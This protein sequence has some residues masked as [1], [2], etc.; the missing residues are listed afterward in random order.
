ME[1]S[2]QVLLF[3][4]GSDAKFGKMN[5]SDGR[6]NKTTPI[7]L[8]EILLDSVVPFLGS[9]S[10]RIVKLARQTI[11][12]TLYIPVSGSLA[13][14][15]KTSDLPDAKS[16]PRTNSWLHK[17]HISKL[18]VEKVTEILE[19]LM[20]IPRY[21]IS[22]LRID[23]LL[24]KFASLR[25]CL[26]VS[27]FLFA[28]IMELDV[29][30]K[31]MIGAKFNVKIQTIYN[32]FWF[33]LDYCQ[34]ES[35]LDLKSL[36]IIRAELLD[37][38]CNNKSLET[39]NID[40]GLR[41]CSELLIKSKKALTNLP[42]SQISLCNLL[43][44]L[45]SISLN[46][47]SIF[48]FQQCI[49][50]SSLQ[51]FLYTE[52]M[53]LFHPYLAK[54]L[55]T[56]LFVEIVMLQIDDNIG[57]STVNELEEISNNPFGE[58]NLELKRKQLLESLTL[59]AMGD[60][61]VATQDVRTQVKQQKIE[62]AFEMMGRFN[63]F[64][65]VYDFIMNCTTD[66]F[67]SLSPVLIMSILN[68]LGIIVCV[69]ADCFDL[70][71]GMC[72]KCDNIVGN[73]G[74]PEKD[75]T[76]NETVKR[77]IAALERLLSLNNGFEDQILYQTT[78]LISLKRVFTHCEAPDYEDSNLIFSWLF[79][80]LQSTTR[81]VRILASQTIPLL[82]NE[83]DEPDR[84][85]VPGKEYY[86]DII[87]RELLQI[88]INGKPY[89]SESTI[90]TW[91]RLAC[92]L[93]GERLNVILI[94][95]IDFLGF[96]HEFQVSLAFHQ[97]EMTAKIRH[98]TT[99]QLLS[100]FMPNISL[101]VVKQLARKSS[102][103]QRVSDFINVPLS[104]F[105]VRTQSFTTPYIVLSGRYQ[106]LKSIAQAANKSILNLCM[107]NMEAILGVLLTSAD[108]DNPEA[109][110]EKSASHKLQQI[111]SKFR[112]PIIVKTLILSSPISYAWEI[113]KNVGTD[114]N[115]PEKSKRVRQ[116]LLLLASKFESNSP[117]NSQDS[118]QSF[119]K[120][121]LLGIVQLF[122]DVI[123][124]TKGRKPFTEKLRAV[125]AIGFLAEAA[126][127][128]IVAA[129]PQLC[130]CF[131]AALDIPELERVTFK[132]FG[133]LIE[134]LEDEHL[135]SIIDLV[136]SIVL[137]RWVKM[138]LSTK[139]EAKNI[140]T[141]IISKGP[142][143]KQRYL[144]GLP[145]FNGVSELEEIQEKIQR[146]I[147]STNA[148]EFSIDMKLRNYIRRCSNDNPY[149]VKQTLEEI[150]KYLISN[151]D[152]FLTLK[153]DKYNTSISKLVMSLLEVI[154]KF[155]DNI[156][157][158]PALSSNCLGLIG[159]I[160]VNR[161]DSTKESGDLIILSNF[162]QANESID[163]VI[164]FVQDHL[165]SP[166]WASAD[167]G[168]QLFLAYAMQ[169]YL[170][171]CSLTESVLNGNLPR[172]SPEVIM[173]HSFNEMSRSTLTPLLSSRYSAT[174]LAPEQVTYPIYDLTKTTYSQWL[175]KFTLD[176]LGRARGH[177]SEQIFRVCRRIIKDQDLSISS[178]VLPY[179]A[180]NVI[181]D[182]SDSERKNITNEI[183]YVLK[184]DISSLDND[185]AE[186]LR[187]CYQTIF[188]LVDYFSKWLHSH[189]QASSSKNRGHTLDLPSPAAIE[190]I[191]EVIPSELMAKRSAECG[192]YPRAIL[193]LE[194]CWRE[195][196]DDPIK[197]DKLTKIDFNDTIQSMYAN[198]DDPDSLDGIFV[199]F[200]NNSI[201]DKIKQLRYSDN[202]W[203][204][205]QE[206]YETLDDVKG[207]DKYTID[208]LECLNEHSMHEELLKQINEFIVRK[209]ISESDIPQEWFGLALEA[210]WS[211]GRLNEMKKW[212]KL[213]DTSPNR[214][215]IQSSF[216]FN[217]SKTLV[218]LSE[219]NLEGVDE[220]LKCCREKIWISLTS[221]T[222]N[223]LSQCRSALVKL[224]GLSDLE[225]IAKSSLSDEDFIPDSITRILDN[226]ISSV[227]DDFQSLWYLLSIRRSADILTRYVI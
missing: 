71:I 94:K 111:S 180:L 199:N 15:S 42:R 211:T 39:M 19:K 207:G 171:F 50:P 91:G 79:N 12:L 168:K 82:I 150:K 53:K 167:P 225:S 196:H 14:D 35:A 136:F 102:I 57:T 16:D 169:E 56:I 1:R 72:R 118:L 209:D 11:Q 170:R 88:D 197:K 89:L 55:K 2:P 113:L 98:K 193:Y 130:T 7:Y 190:N 33:I 59:L 192:D 122:S 184:T 181:I 86:S 176:L 213:S 135:G 174:V 163:F 210:S 158:I 81:D 203:T 145:D 28:I 44:Y 92:V 159:G 146:V 152:Q 143:I 27:L 32:R 219:E 21:G 183:L 224:H 144:L 160:D 189:K 45:L 6:K 129:L 195:W 138:N 43:L 4:I 87:F 218:D 115:N 78:F 121:N 76:N 51:Q 127:R 191:L 154:N 18:I 9:E 205:A 223:S 36:D 41:W 220:S 126:G 125:K 201:E 188:L 75:D 123:H 73:K 142:L 52:N 3:R 200:S 161:F 64:E 140:L 48:S 47:K 175:R 164:T 22:A 31:L 179:I 217:I 151:Q 120:L 104:D 148:T 95:L 185:L 202:N 206:F 108:L 221:K 84:N 226:R 187:S 137:Q 10:F 85:V 208:L 100:P 38:M 63:S 20:N 216:N 212:I 178:F 37:L 29:K 61:R 182:G 117:S 93:E 116:S 25:Q 96:K 139:L 30:R 109:D 34:T 128:N 131:Q 23:P 74:I 77:V 97:L 222:I 17:R 141:S 134:N 99:Y 8:Y 105:L 198:V 26:S 110:I 54:C 194:E 5:I 166:F 60:L 106:V 155:K 80:R 58:L 62:F 172:D 114:E 66:Q 124:D 83:S 147:Q 69:E 24:S 68:A 215:N 149:V 204:M 67:M 49:P 173:W 103:A 214:K 46:S 107:D 162:T 70:H 132:S 186:S 90:L 101:M 133:F 157:D 13:I 227:G 153:S 65:E 177:N 156:T 40:Q 119:L 112:D 165:V